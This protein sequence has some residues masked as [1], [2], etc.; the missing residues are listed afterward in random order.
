MH[1]ELTQSRQAQLLFHGALLF[2]G[3]LIAGLGLTFSLLG[4]FEIWPIIGKIELELPGT[5]RAWLRSHLGLIINGLG[6]WV[7]ALIAGKLLLSELQQ[8]A[9]VI[10]VLVTAWFNSAGFIIG[11]LF[12]VHGLSFGDSVANSLTYFFFLTAVLTVFIQI[13]LVLIGARRLKAAV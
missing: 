4:H 6:I 8:K 3:G 11:T 13:A 1:N 9:Y 10:C 5:S 2:T 7:F 12:G